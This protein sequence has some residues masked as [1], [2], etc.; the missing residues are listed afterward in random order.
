MFKVKSKTSSLS[1]FQAYISSH[2]QSDILAF[3]ERKKNRYKKDY[4]N[5]TDRDAIDYDE[6]KKDYADF[7]KKRGVLESVIKYVHGHSTD[8]HFMKM[9]PVLRKTRGVFC[10][11]PKNVLHLNMRT[12]LVTEYGLNYKSEC[13]HRDKETFESI[14]I[15]IPKGSRALPLETHPFYNS[16]IPLPDTYLI[17]LPPGGHLI[18]IN[19]KAYNKFP[20][21]IYSEGGGG[22]TEYSS[23][24]SKS[25]SP[26][27]TKSARSTSKSKSKSKSQKSIPET[28]DF[29]KAAIDAY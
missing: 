10:C 11:V 27:K 12:S 9:C 16:N 23:S 18:P 17:I 15:V 22:D 26:N 24:K 14:C 6:T 29:M 25:P 2:S 7:Y 5:E 8:D 3:W 21:Y 20:I 19:K 13:R 4:Y 1:P 28:P